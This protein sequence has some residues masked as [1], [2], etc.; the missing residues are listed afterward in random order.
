MNI[1]DVANKANVSIATVSRVINNSPKVSD[2]TR[3]KVLDI[4][5]ELK[6]TPNVFARGLGLNTMKTVG[7]LCSD[8]SDL[9]VARALSYFEKMLRE[10]G[11]DSLLCCSGYDTL[12][13]KKYINIL[14]SKNVDAIIMIGSKYIS[15][16][17][18]ISLIR[19]TSNS[20][21]ILLINGFVKGKNIY[22]TCYDDFNATKRAVEMLYN[23]GRRK[24]LFLYNS[25]SQSAKRKTDGFI[26]GCT[27]TGLSNEC[28]ST[29]FCTNDID[30]TV[31]KLRN[32]TRDNFIPHGVIASDDFL[33]M[34]T[35]KFTKIN[36]IQVPQ[37][38]AIIG[39]D[40]SVLSKLSYP[41]LTTIDS[42]LFKL[43]SRSVSTLMDVFEGKTPQNISVLEPVIIERDTFK[44]TYSK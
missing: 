29:L 19:S 31:L 13:L 16:K 7:I 38:I 36:N 14:I 4:I 6:F 33:G 42:E 12:N 39:Y 35:L 44:N 11:Y 1:Y 41:E 43:C 23:D 30:D 32:F 37:D 10:N 18:N 34:I 22:C 20:L 40:N 27:E 21:P 26:Q 2:K 8:P 3:Q 9:Y 5:H 17:E 28:Y 24:L 25:R 15:G